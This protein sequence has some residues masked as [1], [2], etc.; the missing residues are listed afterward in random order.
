[1]AF[2]ITS[3]PTLL[4]KWP[5]GGDIFYH[6]HI[7]KLYL[8]HGITFWDPLTS[9]PFGRPILYP[10]LFHL[11]LLS[12]NLLFK[13]DI[14]Q[15]ARFLQ[16]V[17]TMLI[18]FSFS[19]VAYKLYDNVLIGT[20][21]GFFIFFSI[22]FERFLLPVPENIA[23]ILFPLALYAFYSSVE[24]KNFKYVLL[25]GLMAGMILLTHTLSFLC[26]FIVISLFC[27]VI[28]FRKKAVIQYYLLFV[29]LTTLIASI[30]WLPLIIQYGIT[31]NL[32]P[33]FEVN[34]IKYPIY[35]GIIPTVFAILGGFSM[36][37]RKSDEDFLIL[38]FLIAIFTLANLYYLGVNVLSNRILT[39]A[40]FPFM[41]MAGVGVG[42]LKAKF[43]I[44]YKEGSGK[45]YF[46]IILVIIYLS[47]IFS[48]FYMSNNVK[49]SPSWLRVSNSQLEVA[50][51]FK[52]QGDKE[53]VVVAYDYPDTLIVALSRQ[54]VAFGG[55]GEGLSK[56]LDV[57]KYA[58]GEVNRSTFLTDKVG[59]IVMPFS[60]KKPSNT[61][62]VYHNNDY[63]TYVF[64]GDRI[65]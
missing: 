33:P 5:L 57:K 21:T 13:S 23:L 31:F 15:I 51:W 9:A 62:L 3:I 53:Y 11:I 8:E 48:G 28:S 4:Y 45:R 1:M 39:F 60:M 52:E 54:P 36:I 35:F 47:A 20:S 30:W 56:H 2:C 55:Y 65:N 16:P 22:L 37:K 38:T 63:A 49:Y 12:L 29:G 24:N 50:E 41:T 18:F 7:A 6:V 61:K 44:K 26:L 42:L 19:Y 32:Q 25:S 10:P 58:Y 27:T 46:Y 17:L 34:P 59:Y 14:F 64:Q 40:I 43:E